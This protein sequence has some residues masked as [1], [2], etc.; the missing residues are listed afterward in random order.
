[1]SNV[2]KSI[3]APDGWNTKGGLDLIAEFSVEKHGKRW[4]TK[5]SKSNHIANLWFV[6][7]ESPWLY[8]YDFYNTAADAE[9]RYN[10][11]KAQFIRAHAKY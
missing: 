4:Y 8:T 3:T 9:K 7:Y 2:D 10:K 1:M 5:I 11:T 6:S